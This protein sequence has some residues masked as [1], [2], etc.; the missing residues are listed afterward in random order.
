MTTFIRSAFYVA[1]PTSQASVEDWNTWLKQDNK[2][3]VQAKREF[4]K[5]NK[6]KRDVSDFPVSTRKIAGRYVQCYTSA[7]FVDAGLEP[8][9]E[10][11][12]EQVVNKAE[13]K[14]LT[15]RSHG[16]SS[17]KDKRATRRQARKAKYRGN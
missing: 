14:G 8:A 4:N 11:E 3:A 7:A 13:S 1:P 17:H 9:V 6:E 16:K 10:A 2:A 15:S 12:Q 5:A